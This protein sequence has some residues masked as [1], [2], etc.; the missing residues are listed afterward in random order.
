[1]ALITGIND[2]LLYIHIEKDY[3]TL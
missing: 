3:F 2:S 1:M